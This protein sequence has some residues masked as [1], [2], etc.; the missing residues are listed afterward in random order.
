MQGYLTIHSLSKV[1]RVEQ[2]RAGT[3]MQL[4][5]GGDQC[6]RDI[7][8]FNMLG[9]RITLVTTCSWQRENPPPYTPGFDP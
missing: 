6:F 3:F 4:G 2:H 7:L 9:K 5:C 1:G 8:R